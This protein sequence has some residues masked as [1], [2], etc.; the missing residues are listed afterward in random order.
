MSKRDFSKMSGRANILRQGH[1]PC[2]GADL[3]PDA[4]KSRLSKASQRAKAARL[5][6]PSTMITKMIE[7]RCGHKGKVRIPVAR[8]S[9]PFR[10]VV[11][12]RAAI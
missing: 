9:G 10:C 8:A 2:D 4:H 1:E 11:C 3:F 6:S 7:C 5:I 12:K